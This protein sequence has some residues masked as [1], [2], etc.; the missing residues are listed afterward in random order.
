MN[1]LTAPIDARI[2]KN[3]EL[4]NKMKEAGVIPEDAFEDV[5]TYFENKKS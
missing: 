5:E 4:L 2:D 1:Y 3:V